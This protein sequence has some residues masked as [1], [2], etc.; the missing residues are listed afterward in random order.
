MRF[1]ERSRSGNALSP[2][3][4]VH[5]SAL[6]EWS[7]VDQEMRSRRNGSMMGQRLTTERSRSGNALSPELS[8]LGGSRQ[9]LSEVDQEMRSRRN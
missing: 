8:G 1:A 2:E 5:D 3:L 7:E 9:R 6:R 4:T